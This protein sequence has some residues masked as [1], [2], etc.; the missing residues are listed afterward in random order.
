MIAI[1]HNTNNI[2]AILDHII[3]QKTK[4]FAQF[5]LPKTFTNNSGI[6]V[7]ND[8]TV[9]HIMKSEIQ[10]FLAHMLAHCTRKLAHFINKANPN[11][12]RK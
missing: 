10:S 11:T 9:S 3:F 5:I 8:T 6:D 7:Q 2:L 1:T 12:N 4:S